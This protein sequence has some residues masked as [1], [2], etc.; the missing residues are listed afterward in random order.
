MNCIRGS[1][2]T[3]VL[4]CDTQSSSWLEVETWGW[5]VQHDCYSAKETRR[6]NSSAMMLFRTDNLDTF[7]FMHT[8]EN[9]A[10]LHCE[11]RLWKTLWQNL[12]MRLKNHWPTSIRSIKIHQIHLYDR[13]SKRL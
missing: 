2:S 5:N 4:D 11:R 1:H 9:D 12:L 6:G 7:G 10:Q 8:S 3:S 13:C